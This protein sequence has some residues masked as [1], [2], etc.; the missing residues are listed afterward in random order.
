MVPEDAHWDDGRGRDRAVPGP[1]CAPQ[2]SKMVGMNTAELLLRRVLSSVLLSFRPPCSTRSCNSLPASSTSWSVQQSAC[3]RKKTRGPRQPSPR[4]AHGGRRAQNNNRT[5]KAA[6]T[7]PAGGRTTARPRTTPD[8]TRYSESLAVWPAASTPP[9]TVEASK[10][11]LCPHIESPVAKLT[12][13]ATS[14][15]SSAAAPH[16]AALRASPSGADEGAPIGCLSVQ[17][18][19][20][21]LRRHHA[22][23]FLS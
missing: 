1:A 16:G 2:P 9:H 8:G 17:P 11:S 13:D 3:S 19:R 22:P 20:Q 10:T 5:G 23:V 4:T 7:A 12:T 21:S 6:S 18:L 15:S 14:S